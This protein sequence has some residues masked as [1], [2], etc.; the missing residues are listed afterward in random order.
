[1]IWRTGDKVTICCAGCTVP[2]HVILAAGNGKALMLGFD[3]ILDG[4]VGMMPVLAD[5]AGEFQ[6][7]VTGV[8]V[9]LG[10]Q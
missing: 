10:P 3:G 5:D 1:M 9:T 7:I 6:S 8:A 2:G 4:H